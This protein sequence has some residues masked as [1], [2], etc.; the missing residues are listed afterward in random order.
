MAR[1]TNI[2]GMFYQPSQ[3]GERASEA[4]GK[5]GSAISGLKKAEVGQAQAD[6]QKMLEDIKANPINMLVKKNMDEQA[7]QL[8]DYQ[9]KWADVYTKQRG[10]LTPKQEIEMSSDKMALMQFQQKVKQD[11]NEFMQAYDVVQK[12]YVGNYDRDHF[13]DAYQQY[14]QTGQKPNDGFLMPGKIDLS[15]A[16]AK[17]PV[18]GRATT[19]STEKKVGDKIVT[20]ANTS[21]PEEN[22][23]I[24]SDDFI[25][26]NPRALRTAQSEFAA[27]PYDRQQYYM[28]AAGGDQLK[29]IQDAAY[30]THGQ[31]MGGRKTSVKTTLDKKGSGMGITI[32]FGNKANLTSSGARP[33]SI[34]SENFDKTYEFS[35]LSTPRRVRGGQLSGN[36]KTIRDTGDPKRPYETIQYK[37]KIQGDYEVTHY[38]ADKDVIILKEPSQMGETVAGEYNTIIVPRKGNEQ[39]LEGLVN[40]VGEENIGD[41]KTT[42]PS[43]NNRPVK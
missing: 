21:L 38:D 6:Y 34:G 19:Y 36:I 37:P 13:N 26:T 17:L 23:R 29:A 4:L 11:E 32:G 42:K 25:A 33:L 27:L 10:K 39:L 3:G 18:G 30:D 5:W 40:F 22:Y 28:S 1:D 31:L 8:Q 15:A 12:D 24:A 41:G 2:G 20:T 9:N 7:V 43:W 35:K 14:M 16:Y